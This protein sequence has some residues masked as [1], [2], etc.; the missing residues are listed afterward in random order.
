[1]QLVQALVSFIF[2]FLHLYIYFLNSVGIV[3]LL[4][5]EGEILRDLALNLHIHLVLHLA[6]GFPP[7]E[8]DK[9]C[10]ESYYK[11]HEQHDL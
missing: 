1:M 7:A 3:L 6:A 10:I 8:V 4:L 5:C 2:L 9:H 11:E